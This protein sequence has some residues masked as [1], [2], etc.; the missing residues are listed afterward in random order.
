MSSVFASP[1]SSRSSP[2]RS[3]R[4]FVHCSFLHVALEVARDI[5]S[6][7]PNCK[8]FQ[9]TSYTVHITNDSSIES[10]ATIVVTIIER[11]TH[12]TTQSFKKRKTNV[13]C[14]IEPKLQ[15]VIPPEYFQRLKC[16]PLPSRASPSWHLLCWSEKFLPFRSMSLL[17]TYTWRLTM[18]W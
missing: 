6:F 12:R 8:F 2:S 18:C 15:D 9:R 7:D 5:H 1:L 3:L 10:A 14:K 16:D 17:G 13:P 4:I 11:A